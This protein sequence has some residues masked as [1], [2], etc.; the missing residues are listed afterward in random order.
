MLNLHTV[1]NHFLPLSKPVN[2][3][4]HNCFPVPCVPVGEIASPSLE[5]TIVLSPTIVV[6]TGLG[7]VVTMVGVGTAGGTP[8]KDKFSYCNPQQFV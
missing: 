1:L 4:L 5:V 2:S 6:V 7:S 8:E 3:S